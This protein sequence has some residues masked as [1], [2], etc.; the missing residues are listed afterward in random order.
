[1]AAWRP[2]Q[3][4]GADK[5]RASLAAVHAVTDREHAELALRVQDIALDV[6][7][8][9]LWAQRWTSRGSLHIAARCTQVTDGMIWI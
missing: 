6:G 2:E 5:L 9:S 7:E 4:I 1:M 8:E 3:S